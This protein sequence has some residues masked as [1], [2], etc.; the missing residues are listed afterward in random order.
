MTQT[1]IYLHIWS[2]LSFLAVWVY[3]CI[4][5]FNL[6]SIPSPLL[7]AFPLHLLAISWCCL[8]VIDT[9]LFSRCLF[10]VAADLEEAMQCTSI[11]DIYFYG[12]VSGLMSFFFL[13]FCF[14]ALL[15]FLKKCGLVVVFVPLSDNVI[16]YVISVDSFCPGY[17]SHFP[18]YL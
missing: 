11:S 5:I 18:T 16:I 13:L 14:Y 3:V 8:T 9:V 10:C 15:L 17:W 4:K 12:S 7:L 6:F 2:S 1:V